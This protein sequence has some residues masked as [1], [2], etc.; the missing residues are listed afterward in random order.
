MRRMNW[1]GRTRQKNDKS[2]KTLMK[3]C[4][5]EKERNLTEERNE[6]KREEINDEEIYKNF[7]NYK[8]FREIWKETETDNI[9]KEE[10]KKEKEKEKKTSKKKKRRRK[11][12][13]Q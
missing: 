3:A 12:K 6:A 13:K 11:Q 1:I 7:K 9:E 4:K 5:W 2:L 8:E 10:K